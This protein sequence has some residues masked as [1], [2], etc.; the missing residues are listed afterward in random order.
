M[1][2]AGTVTVDFAAEVARF[3]AQMKQVND[4]V[5]SVESGFKKMAGVVDSALKLFS[6]GIA[7]SF[8]RSAAEAA[9]ALGKTADKLGLTTER[10]TAFQLA[11]ADAGV[12]AG[13]L[14]KLLVDSQRRL[15]DAAGGTGATADA[16]RILGLNVRDLQRLSPDELF[17]RYADAL[18]E[19]KNRSEQFTLAQD[20]MGKSVQDAYTLIAAGRGAIDEA[21][22][23]VD[24]LGLAISRVD[25]AKI[26]VAN[27]KLALLAKTSQAFGQQVA[28]ALA[29]FVSEFVDRLTSTGTSIDSTR[30]K[31]EAFTTAVFVAFEIIANGARVFDIAVSGAL[32]ALVR[33]WERFFELVRRS[34]EFTAD[35]DA[36]LGFDSL[37][38]RFTNLA[39]TIGQAESFA[40]ALSEQSA[41]RV[42]NAADNI[43]SFSQIFE[44][45]EQIRARAQQQAEEAAA[46]QAELAAGI[47]GAES[48]IEKKQI[49]LFQIEEITQLHYDNML[50]L[51]DDFLRIQAETTEKLDVERHRDHLQR[52]IDRERQA[53][54]QILAVKQGAQNAALGLLGVLAQRSKVAA[55]ALIAFEK[56]RAI[57]QAKINTAVAVTNALASVPYPYNFAAAAEV[58]AFGNIQVALIAATGLLE[59][60]NVLRSSAPGAP[61]GSPQNP[62]FT[63]ANAA[64][65]DVAGPAGA[66]QNKQI[67]ITFNGLFTKDAAREIAEHLKDVIDNSDIHIIGPNSS[68]ARELRGE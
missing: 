8:I 33:P 45:A 29:P 35:L 15:G 47:T 50:Q 7:A 14:A 16:L 43:R 13:T 24:R 17:L 1:A 46:R 57:A 62:V 68:Q 2:N 38:K 31:L 40:G 3:N 37:A 32:F 51:Q 61:L 23:T 67:T 53:E 56:I 41:A 64:T 22:A 9:D 52:K 18:G 6:V 28:A 5:K 4:R 58:A 12:E 30:S 34:L 59:A 42:K 20:L 66:Q 65:G 25:I 26:E 10:L 19:V 55:I 44:E 49:E 48:V 39:Q 54:Q 36:A 63:N 60:G 11:A 21:A 27:D